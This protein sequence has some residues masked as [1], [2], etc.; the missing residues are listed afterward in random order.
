MAW[1]INPETLSSLV[2]WRKKIKEI[3][4]ETTKREKMGGTTNLNIKGSVEPHFQMTLLVLFENSLERLLEDTHVE[5]IGEDHV[6]VRKVRERLHLQQTDL[7]ETSREY[8]NRVAILRR[9]SSKRLVELLQGEGTVNGESPGRNQETKL[10][11]LARL[12]YLTL[13]LS[14]S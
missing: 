9:T 14:I 1:P 2:V 11:L 5:R 8:I 3:R 7:V 12:K 13:S 10:T 6:A 4:T